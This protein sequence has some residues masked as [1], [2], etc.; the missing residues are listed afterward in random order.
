[1]ARL[2][3]PDRSASSRANDVADNLM[4]WQ[5]RVQLQWIF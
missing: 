5:F 1:V 3:L 4:L 2:N